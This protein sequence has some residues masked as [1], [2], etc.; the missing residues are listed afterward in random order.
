MLKQLLLLTTLAGVPA[1]CHS[2]SN[3]YSSADERTEDGM[4][5]Y[6]V[7]GNVAALE[8]EDGALSTGNLIPYSVATTT[9]LEYTD[10]SL[11]TVYPNPTKD[12]LVLTTGELKNLTMTLTNAE[13]QQLLSAQVRDS[14]TRI[15]FSRYASGLYHLTLTQGETIVKSFSIVKK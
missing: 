9:G 13:G 5:I 2:Q 6:H 11:L 1:L 15:D 14:E 4:T 12:V 8:S 10:V 7:V 3:I